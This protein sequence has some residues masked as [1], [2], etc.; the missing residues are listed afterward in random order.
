M[1]SCE[2]ICLAN[3]RKLSGRCVA[4]LRIDGQGWI[5]PVGP[6]QDGTLYTRHYTLDDGTEAKV[7]DIL[8]IDIASPRPQPHQPENWLVGNIPW[9]L[10]ARPAPESSLPIL[11]SHLVYG[12]DLLGNRSDRVPYDSFS[13]APA[14]ASLALVMPDTMHW[15]VR[16]NIFSGRRQTRAFFTL[17]GT[18]YDLSV[19]DPIWEQ[20]L[21]TPSSGSFSRASIGL[22]SEDKI[23]LTISL[24]EPFQGYCYKLV[25][26]VIVVSYS[27]RTYL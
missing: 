12:P 27:W 18:S 4:G 7:L 2:I 25:A 14:Q 20:R 21:A 26:A 23:L 17:G 3:S 22:S 6:A 5:R 1:S 13:Q 9:Q 24:G 11:Y 10:I 19:T 16:T 8:R 15:D